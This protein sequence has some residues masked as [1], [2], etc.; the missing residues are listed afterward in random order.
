MPHIYKKIKLLSY[1]FLIVIIKLNYKTNKKN[2]KTIHIYF[3][4]EN[5]FK[6]ITILNFRAKIQK[7]V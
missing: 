7:Y 5:F 2:R 4:H 1:Y 3:I 6:K